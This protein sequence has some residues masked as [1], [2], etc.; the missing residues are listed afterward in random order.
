LEPHDLL[1]GKT[2]GMMKESLPV[3]SHLK[4]MIEQDQ[5]KVHQHRTHNHSNERNNL[6]SILDMSKK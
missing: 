6:I 4:Q 1:Q 3:A 5:Q 2:P